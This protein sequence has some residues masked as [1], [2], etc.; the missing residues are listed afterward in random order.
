LPKASQ[1][2]ETQAAQM[3]AEGIRHLSAG[4]VPAARIRLLKAAE[5]GSAEAAQLLGD[6]YDPTKLLAFGVRG[7]VGDAEQAKYWYKRAEELGRAS[8]TKRSLA[9]D[10]KK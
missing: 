1:H 8:D 2:L 4:H 3:L 6:S 9:S 7:L 5:S 10:S